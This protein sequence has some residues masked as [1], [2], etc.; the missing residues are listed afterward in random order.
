[1]PYNLDIKKLSDFDCDID[2]E[3]MDY[4]DG[5]FDYIVDHFKEEDEYYL[6]ND[7]KEVGFG[8]EETA[9]FLARDR[10]AFDVFNDED[11]N[12]VYRKLIIRHD[13]NEAYEMMVE[14]FIKC[15]KDKPINN[16][17]DVEEFDEYYLS[18]LNDL[19]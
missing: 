13:V 15:M 16:N 1:M 6:S 5:E 8:S 3:Y 7:S 19:D 2:T 9:D 12:K 17:E 11:I 4:F 18:E 10:V 14:T